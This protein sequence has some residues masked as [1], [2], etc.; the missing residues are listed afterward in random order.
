[1]KKYKVAAYCQDE[2][3]FENVQKFYTE[4]EVRANNESEAEDKAERKY[5]DLFGFTPDTVEVISE[6]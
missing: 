2:P 5:K 4:I 3:R 6:G 1:M